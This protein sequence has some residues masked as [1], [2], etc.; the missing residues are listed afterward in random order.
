[1][2]DDPPAAES[3]PSSAEGAAPTNDLGIVLLLAYQSFVRAL[4]RDLRQHGFDSLRPTDGYVFRALADGPRRIVDLAH[5][6][7]VTKQAASQIVGDMEAR[8]LVRRRPDPTDGRAALV[9]L[10]AAGR[11]AFD[12]AR[13][14]HASFEDDLARRLGPR[15]ST[16]LRAGL[17]SIVDAELGPDERAGLIRLP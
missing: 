17:E 11:R 7:E 12:T 14:F 10:T 1:M 8:E 15:R 3:D 9:E 4:H 13:R 5:G 16:T 2:H 6:L